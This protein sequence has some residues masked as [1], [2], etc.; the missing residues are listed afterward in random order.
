MK[1]IINVGKSESLADAVLCLLDEAKIK[2]SEPAYIHRNQEV[3]ETG[4]RVGDHDFGF[5][6]MSAYRRAA[7]PDYPVIDAATEFGKLV[8]LLSSKPATE[9]KLNDSYTAVIDREA[10]VVRVKEDTSIV[11]PF[12]VVAKIVEAL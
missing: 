10:K 7:M 9:L 11:V 6:N 12:D 2:H 5:D 8:E 1:A 4:I 3:S